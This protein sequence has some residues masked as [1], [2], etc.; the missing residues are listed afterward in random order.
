MPDNSDY[1]ALRELLERPD[2][3]TEEDASLIESMIVNQRRAIADMH[4]NDVRGKRL[5]EA[6]LSELVRAIE[7]YVARRVPRN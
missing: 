3:W 5:A 2:S 1:D 4:P 6:L 7:Q